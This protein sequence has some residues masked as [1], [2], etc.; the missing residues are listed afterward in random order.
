MDLNELLKVG[1]IGPIEYIEKEVTWNDNAFTVQVKSAGTP[2]DFEYVYLAKG[3]EDA[4]MARRVHRFIRLNGLP[5][6]YKDVLRLKPSLC[7]ALAAAVNEVHQ[8]D[9]EKKS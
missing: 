3:D 2:A 9:D 8:D 4:Y 1:A 7:M 6:P 5:I